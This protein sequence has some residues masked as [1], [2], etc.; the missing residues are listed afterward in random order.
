M[1][2]ITI[3]SLH[4]VGEAPGPADIEL[5]QT[6][7]GG[8]AVLPCLP[9]RGQR[10]AVEAV[11]LKRKRAWEPVELLYHSNHQHSGSSAPA[12]SRFPVL[13]SLA[14]GPGGFAYNVTLEQLQPDDSALYSCQLHMHGRSDS[15]AGLGGRVF[16]VSV[17]GGSCHQIHDVVAQRVLT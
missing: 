15:A 3:S 1:H 4:P 8:S 16:F 12:S 11:T 13:L 14:P 17:Q 6:C 9:P 7:A 10:S 2:S 5:V